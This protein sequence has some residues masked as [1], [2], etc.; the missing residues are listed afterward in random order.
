MGAFGQDFGEQFFG[1]NG[2]QRLGSRLA[3]QSHLPRFAPDEEP[4]GA[5][6]GRP[7]KIIC[8]GLNYADHARE[9][10]VE[11][12]SEPVLF[13]KATTA[14]CGPHDPLVIPHGSLKTDWEVELA[15]VDRRAGP[16]RE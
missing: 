14:L 3:A 2:P 10:G 8:V 7:S 12:P 16:P 4:V 13:F 11:L 15:V 1:T 9:S 5:P 6:I